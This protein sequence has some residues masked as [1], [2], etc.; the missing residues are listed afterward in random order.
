[1]G[2]SSVLRCWLPVSGQDSHGKRDQRPAAGMEYYAYFYLRGQSGWRVG[3]RD[4]R[5]RELA[6]FRTREVP[7]TDGYSVMLS[8]DP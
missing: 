6:Q 5:N 1:M 3:E 4:G 2:G 8:I 7:R